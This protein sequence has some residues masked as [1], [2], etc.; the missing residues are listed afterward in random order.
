MKSAL[1]IGATGQDGSYLCEYLLSLGYKVFGLRR[2]STRTGI[3]IEGVHYLVGDVLD[4]TSIG[5]ALV[6]AQPNEVYNL[7]ADTFVGD[8]WKHP[9][10]QAE[11]TGLGCVRVLEAL[12]Q[13][14]GSARYVKFYQA[15]T[16]E[17]YGSSPAPQN[18]LT[19]FHPRS[20]YGCA[21]LYAHSITVNY[22]ESYGMSAC[23][24][25]LFNH[26]SERRGAEFVTQKIVTQV[27]EILA[28][29]RETIE[30][31]NLSAKRD[32]G[33]APEYV[34]AM[35]LMLQQPEPSD[36]VVATG[37]THTVGDFVMMAWKQ[38]GLRLGKMRR[39][40]DDALVDFMQVTNSE[41]DIR[42]AET[43]VLCGDASKIRAL[44]WEPKV[45][46]D[47]LA[48]IMLKAAIARVGK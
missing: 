40:S 48:A 39:E 38:A 17:L 2:R 1:V 13:Y 16:S 45:K 15:S 6:A 14:Q 23:C 7:A 22:R 35:H 47:E 32:W 29:K 10:E 4:G 3:E 36:Y 11:V 8:S 26:E 46:V 12:R 33:Y 19:P 20:P 43:N 27:A 5:A 21:K 30:L 34:K 37:E 42:P 31:G 9:L 24:G 18:E 25:I 44:G 41:K 28:G